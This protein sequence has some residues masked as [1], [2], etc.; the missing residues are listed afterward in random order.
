MADLEKIF[1]YAIDNRYGSYSLFRMLPDIDDS[2]ERYC[3]NNKWM[4]IDFV[5]AAETDL[6]EIDYETATIN[7]DKIDKGE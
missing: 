7:R 4:K 1:E 3:G 6:R 2:V 5:E